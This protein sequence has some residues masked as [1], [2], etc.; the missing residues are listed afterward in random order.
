MLINNNFQ[1]CFYTTISELRF[2]FIALIEDP[3]YYELYAPTPVYSIYVDVIWHYDQLGIYVDI[4]V[5][6]LYGH[7]SAAFTCSM[8]NHYQYL[9][10]SYFSS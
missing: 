10:I 7:C 2:S 9:I 6:A 1:Y 8:H 3:Y 4:A 5:L